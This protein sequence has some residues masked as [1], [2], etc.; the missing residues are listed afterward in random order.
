MTSKK[1]S[2]DPNDRNIG[3]NFHAKGSIL[4]VSFHVRSQNLIKSYLYYL[5]QIIK[6]IPQNLKFLF[7][8]LFAMQFWNNKEYLDSKVFEDKVIKLS[9]KIVDKQF[10]AWQ[11]LYANNHKL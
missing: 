9:D 5:G 10:E 2:D 7:A 11:N 4:T 8:A 1:K 3:A 6:L